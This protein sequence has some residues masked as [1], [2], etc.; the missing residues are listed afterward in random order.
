MD[1]T[2]K[3]PSLGCARLLFFAALAIPFALCAREIRVSLLD[4]DDVLVETTR[5]VIQNGCSRESAE[6]F[7]NAVRFHKTDLLDTSK[8]PRKTSG[9]YHFKSVQELNK[10]FP[11]I[12]CEKSATNRS[13]RGYHFLERNASQFACLPGPRRAL[14]ERRRSQ[15]PET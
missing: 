13:F 14:D 7:V 6:A 3:L 1:A 8:L 4:D 11:D 2:T 5:L 9:F 10:A 15:G 12:F